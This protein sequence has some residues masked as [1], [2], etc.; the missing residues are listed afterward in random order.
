MQDGAYKHYRA[1]FV[2][3]YRLSAAQQ[4]QQPHSHYTT[5][6][7][8]PHSMRSVPLELADKRLH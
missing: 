2:D 6:R 4:Q 3:A 8:S 5:K 1:V 7:R